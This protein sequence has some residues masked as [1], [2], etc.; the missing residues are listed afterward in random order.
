MKSAWQE[1]VP[2][3][4]KYDIYSRGFSPTEIA[5]ML[6]STAMDKRD[7]DAFDRICKERGITPREGTQL[8]LGRERKNRKKVEEATLKVQIRHM[9]KTL[10]RATAR[11]IARRLGIR[12]DTAERH[13]RKLEE[14][15]EVRAVTVGS[16]LLWE[17]R[18]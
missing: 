8:R 9:I 16:Q 11:K 14:N 3:A 2:L 7:R 18:V 13:L 5:G 10:G 4:I 1:L 17:S 6:D 12:K 15:G